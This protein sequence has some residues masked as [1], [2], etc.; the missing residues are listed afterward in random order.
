MPSLWKRIDVRRKD[1]LV[2]NPMNVLKRFRCVC[3]GTRFTP[4]PFLTAGI[5]I[6][7]S[8]GLLLGAEPEQPRRFWGINIPFP[9]AAGEFAVPGEYSPILEALEVMNPG[10]VRLT[11]PMPDDRDSSPGIET[12]AAQLEIFAGKRDTALAFIF[13]PDFST[14]SGTAIACS[15]HEIHATS[16]TRLLNIE[17]RCSIYP[18]LWTD[19]AFPPETSLQSHDDPTSRI[20]MFTNSAGILQPLDFPPFPITPGAAAEVRAHTATLMFSGEER[21]D[22]IMRRIAVFDL[23]RNRGNQSHLPLW[24]TSLSL[25]AHSSDWKSP[26]NQRAAAGFM[27]R[28]HVLAAASGIVGRVYWD[29]LIESDAGAGRILC[30]LLDRNLQITDAGLAYRTMSRILGDMRYSGALCPSSGTIAHLF[31]G[32]NEWA[33]VLW[34]VDGEERISIP[35]AT[36]FLISDMSGSEK[37]VPADNGFVRLTLSREPLYVIGKGPGIISP[38]FAVPRSVVAHIQR[39]E[40][41]IVSLEIESSGGNIEGIVEIS[42]I[43][44]ISL[45]PAAITLSQDRGN[46]YIC[47][48]SIAASREMNAGF[49][50][51]KG[52]MKLKS[53]RDQSLFVPLWVHVYDPVDISMTGDKENGAFQLITALKNL[54]DHELQGNLAWQFL[55]RGEVKTPPRHVKISSGSVFRDKA[56]LIYGNREV[57]LLAELHLDDGCSVAKDIPLISLPMRLNYPVVD[58]LLKEWTTVPALTLKRSSQPYP[59]NRELSDDSYADIR[60]WWTQNA[61]FLSAEIH[62]EALD[63]EPDLISPA[64]RGDC[65]EIVLDNPGE[66]S[67][68]RG[69]HPLRV[70]LRPSSA[71]ENGI[72]W[73]HM[74][75]MPMAGGK[76]ATR[77]IENGYV[78]EAEIGLP[79]SQRNILSGPG[80]IRMNVVLHLWK[81]KSADHAPLEE[82]I[83]WHG[84]Y[85]PCRGPLDWGIAVIY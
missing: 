33:V 45:N 19:H 75:Q 26:K 65:L 50:L 6:I 3:R 56:G 36:G 8:V 22:E 53:P 58:G 84:E 7:F 21:D 82:Y 68:H 54:A 41:Q 79:E 85:D 14:S 32:E 30:G 38:A 57:R 9:H 2:K 27:I 44:G 74:N 37:H 66:G 28:C 63:S 48:F 34:A 59:P 55:P 72:V 24:I 35:S 15:L 73:D 10:A 16:Y 11:L 70:L 18:G 47:S 67:P 61:L 42:S 62:N 25:S 80:I 81:G 39:S 78:L 64:W 29:G 51:A 31:R 76:I 20:D 71:D 77:T 49:Y 46:G 69:I 5:L 83:P 52:H 1:T 12:S 43:P 13:D 40:A 60:L 4:P 23:Q 17:P